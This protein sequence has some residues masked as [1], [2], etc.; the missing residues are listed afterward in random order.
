MR[1]KW[2]YIVV[3]LMFAATDAEAKLFEISEFFLPNR[4]RV[5]VVENHKAPIAKHMVWYGVGSADEKSGKGGSAHLLEHL[6]FRGTKTVAD[7]KFNALM[8]KNG[9]ESNAFTYF[10][11]TAYHQSLDISRLELVMYLEADRMQ[12]LRFSPEAFAAERDIVLQ[13]RKQM[14]ENKPT[15][16]FGENMLRV[17]WQTHPYGNPVT[18]TEAEIRNLTAADVTELYEHYYS[19]ENAILVVSGDVD[20]Q[21]VYRLALKYYGAIA[22]KEKTPVHHYPELNL[23]SRSQLSMRLPQSQTERLYYFY[24]APS[25]NRPDGQN[26]Y[27]LDILAQYLGGGENS[28]LYKKLVLQQKV[29]AAV[30]VDYNYA[31]RSYGSFVLQ[32]VP[33]AGQDV[34]VLQ[35]AIDEALPAAISD[36]DESELAKIKQKMLA[37]LVYARDNP[38]DAAQIVGTLAVIGMSAAEIADYA[39]NVAAVTLQ[40]VRRAAKNLFERQ[41]M[42]IGKAQPPEGDRNE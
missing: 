18:G 37:G 41:A 16:V 36:F 30:S 25:Y 19:P 6:M 24:T 28:T 34:N 33:A 13:E 38:D 42:V 31:A 39:D 8:Q 4:M 5:L 15:S 20:P 32:A 11:Y 12:N 21:E 23:S 26:V 29:A 1:N 9:I 17:L 27:A 10:D 40:D 7:K 22:N 3:L 14:I 2:W 35:K